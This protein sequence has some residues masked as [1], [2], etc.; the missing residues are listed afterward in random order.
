MPTPDR[1][2][3]RVAAPEE[4]ADLDPGLS[5]PS[6]RRPGP[7]ATPM[8]DQFAGASGV[9]ASESRLG[10]LEEGSTPRAR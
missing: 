8:P 5:L 7:D 1:E 9:G 10:S 6:E 3:G 2:L 4:A